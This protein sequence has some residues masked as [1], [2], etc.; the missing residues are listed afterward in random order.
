MGDLMSTY[1][2]NPNEE[3]VVSF[4]NVPAGRYPFVCDPHAA[5]NMRG[6]VTVQ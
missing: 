5:M 4:T 1:L 2:T 3:V 6:A